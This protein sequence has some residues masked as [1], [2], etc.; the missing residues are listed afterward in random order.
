GLS[1]GLL[2]AISGT[3]LGGLAVVI[4]NAVK[5]RFNFGRQQG[6]V[7][8]SSINLA[9]VL[10]IAAIVVAVAVLAG[11]RPAFQASRLDPIKALR[12]V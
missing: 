11:F 4:L 7:L 3:A 10:V 1:L 12:H 9:D 2:G 8:I 5:I 6:L